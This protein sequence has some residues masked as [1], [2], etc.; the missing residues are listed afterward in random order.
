MSQVIENYYNYPI[1]HG[2]FVIIV[3]RKS[4]NHPSQQWAYSVEG[5]PLTCLPNEVRQVG[6]LTDHTSHERIDL[7][8]FIVPIVIKRMDIG[9]GYLGPNTGSA[10]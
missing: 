6:G 4:N 2:S 8:L 10:P 9:W 7:S 1:L 3:E 5:L